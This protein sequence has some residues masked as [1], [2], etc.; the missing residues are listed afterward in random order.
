M[1]TASEATS[2]HLLESKGVKLNLV[3]ETMNRRSRTGRR[4]WRTEGC[5]VKMAEQEQR[6]MREPIEGDAGHQVTRE[7]MGGAA[8]VLRKR[9]TCYT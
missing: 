2:C 9:Q 4:K 5:Q 3:K 6:Q 1:V 7:A 8:A